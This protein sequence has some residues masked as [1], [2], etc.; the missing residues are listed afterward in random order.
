MLLT[1]K[2]DWNGRMNIE[3]GSIVRINRTKQYGKVMG[4][5]GPIKEYGPRQAVIRISDNHV[6]YKEIAEVS[7]VESIKPC[8]CEDCSR[9]EFV[10]EEK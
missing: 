5:A 10:K 3:I 9:S 4:F 8:M 1:F 2:R 7:V 6:I